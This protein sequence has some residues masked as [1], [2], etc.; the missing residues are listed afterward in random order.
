MIRPALGLEHRADGGLDHV[1]GAEEVDLQDLLPVVDRHAHDQVIAGDAGIVD[2]DVDLAERLE[3]GGDGLHARF[4]IGHVGR[5][6]DGLPT[7]SLD[8]GHG[9]FGDFLASHVHE[10]DVATLSRELQ[11]DCLAYAAGSARDESGLTGE[12]EHMD[13]PR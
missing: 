5:D 10:G 4:R 11:A 7:E 9:G 8:L 6:V 13:P 2:E 12:I 3:G 1:E